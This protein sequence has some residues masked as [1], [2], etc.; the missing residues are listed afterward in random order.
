MI[1]RMKNFICQIIEKFF[2]LFMDR[3]RLGN[4][5]KISDSLP[6]VLEKKLK[7]IWEEKIKA[8]LIS[9]FELGETLYVIFYLGTNQHEI[10]MEIWAPEYFNTKPSEV[11][12]LELDVETVRELK[13]VLNLTENRSEAKRYALNNWS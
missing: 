7:P 3:D 6:D 12:I 8:I 10:I 11:L 1:T 13:S 9:E 4:K 2:T 5:D